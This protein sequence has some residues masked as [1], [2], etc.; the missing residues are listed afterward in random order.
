[1]ATTIQLK[2]ATAA[3]WAELN[4]VLAAGEPGYV[5][6]A[7]DKR[8]CLKI[9]DGK[10][11]WKDLPFIGGGEGE[12]VSADVE[13][14]TEGQ[15]PLLGIAGITYYIRDTKVI[16]RWNSETNKYDTYG[17]SGDL[18]FDDIKMIIGGNANGNN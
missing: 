6:D 18:S 5:T 9:G 12:T 16:K 2:R 14:S 8:F 15:L 4:Y 1:M 10:T 11:A 13:V 7:V 17:G 3:R